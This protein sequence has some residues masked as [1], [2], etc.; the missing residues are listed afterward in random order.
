MALIPHSQ[1]RLV[2]MR[3]ALESALSEQD[4]DKVRQFDLSLMQA[5]NEASEDPERD[6]KTLLMEL[7][8][9]VHLYKDLVLSSELHRTVNQLH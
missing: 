7:N 2:R 4:W 5:L 8:A 1:W 3:K 6:A 9:V